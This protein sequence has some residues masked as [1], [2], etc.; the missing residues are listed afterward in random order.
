M[1]RRALGFLAIAA[2]PLV[3]PAACSSD[4]QGNTGTGGSAGT[5]GGD[6]STAIDP[7][8]TDPG[9]PSCILPP[10]PPTGAPAPPDTPSPT[11]LAISELYLGDAPRGS[12]TRDIN[13][14]KQFG[15]NLDGL[16]ST[17]DGTNH[18]TLVAGANPAATKT[19]G[20][21]GIDN[22]FGEGLLPIILNLSKDAPT[23]INDSLHNGDAT[24]MVRMMNLADTA[25]TP[26]Q[27]GI[28]A[29]LLA[30]AAFGALANCGDG[31]STDP[32]C[33]P[34][35]FDGTDVWP[36]SPNLLNNNDPNDPKIKLDNSYVAGGTWVSGHVPSVDLTITFQG[37]TLTL[38]ILSAIITMKPTGIQSSAKATQGTIAGVLN[39]ATLVES[40]R[41][42]AGLIDPSFC[43]SEA[44]ESVAQQI[45]SASDIMTDGTNGD[46]TKTCD[47][48]SIGIG[49]DAS[50][51]VQ[52]AVAPA[53]TP[54][55]DPCA[56]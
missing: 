13:A 38:N 5:S 21:G 37:V 34:P 20:D 22:G 35:K 26:N 40:L 33:S 6:V 54:P 45:R 16:I 11:V 23:L 44:F 7:K 53:V 55:P 41:S 30:G 43:T 27:S 24:L 39:T 50:A 1:L 52:G 4:D 19:D 12:T 28:K 29:A 46:P 49:F 18:C 47:A 32:N 36:L 14:W 17:G 9:A 8:C 48:I 25:T 3:A 10:G 15:Y 31:G 42:A 56:G 51:V 2:A